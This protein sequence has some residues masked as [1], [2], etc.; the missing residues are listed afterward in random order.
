MIKCV[1]GEFVAPW[2]WTVTVLEAVALAPLFDV[3]VKTYW[4]VEVGETV[5]DPEAETIPIP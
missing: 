1:I 2:V 4:V 5:V 3:A